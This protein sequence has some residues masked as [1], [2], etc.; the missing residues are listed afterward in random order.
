[1][2]EPPASSLGGQG[3]GLGG[4]VRSE[5][6]AGEAAALAGSPAGTLTTYTQAEL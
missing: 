4:W 6:K 3:G 1:M 2:A 5:R